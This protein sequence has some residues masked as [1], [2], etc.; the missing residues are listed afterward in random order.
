MKQLRHFIKD[1]SKNDRLPD[2]RYCK[3]CGKLDP[4]TEE[5]YQYAIKHGNRCK[6]GTIATI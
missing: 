4:Y 5:E 1:N 3:K 6:C 2:I